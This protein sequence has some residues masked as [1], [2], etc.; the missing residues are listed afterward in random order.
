MLVIWVRLLYSPDLELSYLLGSSKT[1]VGSQSIHFSSQDTMISRPTSQISVGDTIQG[2]ALAALSMAVTTPTG[3]LVTKCYLMVPA[4]SGFHQPHCTSGS[5]SH[6]NVACVEYWHS[7]HEF[8]SHSLNER[9]VLWTLPGFM[10]RYLHDK[11]TQAFL[12]P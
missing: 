2:P 11:Y 9:S 7:L 5:I 3:F 1:L 8:I 12:S 10:S 4:S 6:C